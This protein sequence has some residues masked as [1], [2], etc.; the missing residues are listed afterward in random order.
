MKIEQITLYLSYILVLSPFEGAICLSF[1]D[2]FLDSM[3]LL[4]VPYLF[5]ISVTL[6]FLLFEY[7]VEHE[8]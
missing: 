4:L 2:F 8:K 7:F 6:H 5:K 1:S 3:V